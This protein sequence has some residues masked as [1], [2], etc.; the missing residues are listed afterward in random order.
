MRLAVIV[1][2]HGV[3][4]TDKIPNAR[5]KTE[6]EQSQLWRLNFIFSI[7]FN[8]HDGFGGVTVSSSRLGRKRS[9]NRMWYY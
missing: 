7:A 6:T 8:E 1:K 2:Q 9:T 5:P 4:H 3:K